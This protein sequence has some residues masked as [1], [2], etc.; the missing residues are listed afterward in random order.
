[1]SQEKYLKLLQEARQ[2]KFVDSVQI[3]NEEV[4]VEEP[5]GTPAGAESDTKKVEDDKKLELEGRCS[6]GHKKVKECAM[7]VVKNYIMVIAE[8][9]LNV[10]QM[11]KVSKHVKE[12]NVQQVLEFAK[13]HR[14]ALEEGFKNYKKKKAKKN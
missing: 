10:E 7:N 14:K 6:S 12:M 11:A 8:R 1:M 4:K 3:V 9:N 5:E 2:N 13:K